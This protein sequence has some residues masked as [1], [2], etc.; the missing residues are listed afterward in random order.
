MLPSGDAA[1]GARHFVPPR[2][3]GSVWNGTVSHESED[4]HTAV[5]PPPLD[6]AAAYSELQNLL[7]DEP[8]VTDFLKH[9][10][11]LSAA[12]VPSASTPW[13]SSAQ[14]RRMATGNSAPLQP[15]SLRP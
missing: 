8:N 11:T 14:H 6:L 15:N 1:F 9:L 4:Q 3:G 5:R 7:L 13:A 2:A 12:L 10:A